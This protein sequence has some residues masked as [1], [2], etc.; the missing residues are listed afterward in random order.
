MHQPSLGEQELDILQF[1]TEHA[2]ISV[3]QVIEQYGA[4]HGLARATIH[5]MLERLRKKGF[6]TREKRAGVFQYLPCIAKTELLTNLVGD[7][8]QRTLGGSMR[9]FMAYLAQSKDLSAEEL[10]ELK[11]LV[12]ELDKQQG[13]DE[14]AG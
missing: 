5:T 4:A 6:L 7:F 13:G 1:V 9:P 3:S 10:Q 11:A 14:H 12:K 8:F 2:P